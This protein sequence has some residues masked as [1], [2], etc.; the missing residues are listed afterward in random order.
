MIRVANAA[1]S[2]L[3][4]EMDPKAQYDAWKAIEDRGQELLAIYHSHTK[5]AAYPS[6]TDVNQ[7]VAWPDQIYLI[8]SLADEDAAG[9]EGV[10]SKGPEDRRCRARNPLARVATPASRAVAAARVAATD[11]GGGGGGGKLVKVAFAPSQ[12]EAEMIQG[13]L[14]E[15]GI[16]SLVKRGPR[17]RRARVHAGRA[18]PDLR[19]RVGRPAGSRSARGNPRRRGAAGRLVDAGLGDA[20]R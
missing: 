9:R 1:A 11:G 7:A 13:L 20:R 10:P 8:V 6:Q 4:Y 14:S 2:P 12:M 3:R 17:L 18:A 19:H 15:H 16:P 5:S